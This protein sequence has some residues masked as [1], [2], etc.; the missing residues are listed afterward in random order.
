MREWWAELFIFPA[1]EECS[2]PAPPHGEVT[3]LLDAV[4]AGEVDASDQLFALIHDELQAVAENLMRRERPDH[5]LEPA[6]LV[7]EAFLRL[8]GPGGLAKFPNRRYLFATMARVMRRILVEHARRRSTQKRAGGQQRLPLDAVLDYFEQQ[9]VDI[10][11]LHEALEELATIHERPSQV[12]TLR[13]FD[14]LT[15]EE[16]AEHLEVSVM[17]V[18]RDLRIAKAWLSHE[19][20]GVTP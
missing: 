2:M 14:G 4:R 19:L 7:N 3:R 11:R 20:R 17:T 13:Y 16:I 9:D 12:V 15:L 6:A 5:T 1:N 8:L 10:V 18:R